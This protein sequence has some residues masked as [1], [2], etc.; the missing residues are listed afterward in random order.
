MNH[1]MT[2]AAR[3]LTAGYGKQIVLS[4]VSFELAEGQITALIGPN[5]SGK[6]TLLKTLMGDIS[7]LG[8]SV[9]LV[10]RELGTLRRSEIAKEM[11][12]MMT[13]AMKPEWMTCREMI[14]SGRYPYTGLLGKMEEKDILAVESAMEL[15]GTAKLAPL[16]VTEISDGQRQRVLLAKAV[17][18]EPK[19]LILDEPTTYLD[20]RYKL[21][22]VKLLRELARKRRVTILMSLHELELV[23]LISDRVICLAKGCIDADGAPA[24]I[25]KED[26]LRELFRIDGTEFA[27]FRII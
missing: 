14:E 7:P 19:V 13:G 2:L 3:N 15:T 16:W 24:D 22:F 27:D 5:G 4:D 25:L 17:C 9:F 12:V 21:E 1:T 20:I 8:G 10:G 11:A 23:R 18:Q 26:Y 6:S